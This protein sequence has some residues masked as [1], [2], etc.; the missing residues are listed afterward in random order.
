MSSIQNLLDK[1][2]LHEPSTNED[3][4]QIDYE[5]AIVK[6]HLDTVEI[7][8]QM[9]LKT[10]DEKLKQYYNN[11]IN[12]FEKSEIEDKKQ[13]NKSEMIKFLNKLET[14]SDYEKLP[15]PIEYLKSKIDCIAS[16]KIINN[17]EYMKKQRESLNEKQRHENYKQFLIAK[18]NL[19]KE[20][21]D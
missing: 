12:Q 11:I 4:L 19:N 2:C 18:I 14:F 17:I 9:L 21:L 7:Y 3:I 16:K 8:K 15:I 5:E 1:V 10:E 20:D 6:N 13:M